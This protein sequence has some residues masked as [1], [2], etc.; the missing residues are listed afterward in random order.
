[1]EVLPC[2][3]WSLIWPSA[4]VLDE[5]VGAFLL[6]LLEP[7]LGRRCFLAGVGA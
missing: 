2:R 1:M 4:E 3:S 7:G 5:D 6:E